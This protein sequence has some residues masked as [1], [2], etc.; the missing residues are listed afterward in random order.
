DRT[1]RRRLPALNLAQDAVGFTRKLDACFR[2]EAETPDV[3]VHRGVA[4]S[5]SEFDRGNVARLC[6]SFSNRQRSEWLMIVDQAS[7]DS[8]RTHLAVDVIG[9]LSEVLLQRGRESDDFEC[10][11]RFVNVLQC[12]V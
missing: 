5:H 12:P 7:G 10:R 9:G 6:E 1:D 4:D 3:F 11:T 8:D 2:T